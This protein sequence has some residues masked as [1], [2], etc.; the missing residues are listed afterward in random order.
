M[1]INKA[2]RLESVEEYYFSKKLKEISEMD[3]SGEKVINLGIGNPDIPPHPEVLEVLS[4]E[5]QNT[6]N[7][8]YQSYKGIPELRK[9]FSHWYSKYYNTKLDAETEILPLMGSKEGIMHISMA[10][11]NPGD[12]VLVPDPGY[13]TYSSVSKLCG[14]N[15]IYYDLKEEN[16]WLPDIN[17]LEKSELENI[18][19]M[20]INY[21]NMPT[22]A[23]ASLEKLKDIVEF[24]QKN[25]I[26][27]INDNPYSFIL[28][29]KHISIFNVEGSMKN[30]LELNSMSKAHNMAGWRIGMLAGNEDILNNILKIKSNMDSGM[31]KP[32]QLAACKALKLEDK[33]YDNL[34]RKYTKRK[35]I[36]HKIMDC[37]GARY[38]LESTGMFIWA[39][40]P[41][42][43]KSA[44]D[45]SNTI[46]E[47]ARVFITP[48]H[49]FG[50]N[51]INYL[52]I[53]LCTNELLLKQAL[54]KISSALR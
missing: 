1:V 3:K 45:L 43:Y 20:W 40:I 2:K 21:P 41:E 51:G 46:L 44:E 32:I 8:G 7:H 18:K 11:L 47:K 54:S 39:R 38:S 15:I 24:T 29:D 19:I 9:A 49:I 17:I 4:K 42:K 6:G 52:R 33:W 5:S 26:L 50:K 36:A 22:G 35:D 37:I 13:P 27:L 23:R 53:S 48:G 34:N 30:C 10:Y 16:S 14:A 28:N 31:F 12:A 25:N